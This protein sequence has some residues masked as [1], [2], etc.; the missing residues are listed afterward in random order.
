MTP[1]P[2]IH[3]EIPSP[4]LALPLNVWDGEY[5]YQLLLY[6]LSENITIVC[7]W[8]NRTPARQGFFI[9]EK[10]LHMARAY[11]PDALEAWVIS[12]EPVQIAEGTFYRVSRRAPKTT[13]A[14]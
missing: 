12:P 10:V 4:G 1:P 6:S 2:A 5:H 11:A 8:R 13:K 9:S 14:I 7:R 3:Q